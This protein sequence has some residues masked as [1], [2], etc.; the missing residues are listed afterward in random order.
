M[1]QTTRHRDGP[2]PRLPAIA[3]AFLLGVCLLHLQPDIGLP[4]WA[5][6][7][8]LGALPLL[9]WLFYLK[10]SQRFQLAFLIGY[11]WALLAAHS[12]LQQRLEPQWQGEDLLVSGQVSGLVDQGARSLRFNFR[13]EEVRYQGEA[14]DGFK[15]RYLRLSWYH[16][17]QS[18]LPGQRW[19]LQLRLKP[20][21][22]MLN[23]GGFDYEKWLFQQ[24]IH[25]TGYVRNSE[26]N[27]QISGA[28]FSING[29]RQQLIEQISAASDSPHRGLLHALSVGYKSNMRPQHWQVMINTGTSHLMAISGLHIGLVAGMVFFLARLLVPVSLLRFI[30][31]Q[32]FAALL[33]LLAAGFYAALAGFAVP[34]Q[35]AFV[36]LLVVLLALLLKRPA[37]SLNTLSLALL[38]VL[39]LDPLAPLSAGFW[40]S[41]IA[42]LLIAIIIGGRVAAQRGWLQGVRLQWL[43][44]LS[45][46][47]ISVLLFQQGS[48][49]S[50]LANML[51]IPLVGLLIVPMLLT[52]SLFSLFSASLSA[53]LFNAAGQILELTW[54]LLEWLAQSPLASWQ[55]ASL[56]LPHSLLA[57]L[58]GLLLILP[59]GFPLKATGLILLLP[60]IFYQAPRPQSGDFWLHLLDVGQG[61]S[62]L[63]QTRDHTLLYDAGASRGERFDLGRL[64]IEPLLRHKG[65][66][67][68][69]S[70]IISHADNDH[71][72]GADYLLQQF[73]V[74]KVLFGGHRSDFAYEL[75]A[76]AYNCR[77]GQRWRWNQV[78][79]ELLHPARDYHKTNQQSCVLRI[80]SADHSVLLTGDIDQPVESQ[81]IGDFSGQLRS[82]VLL[83]PHHGSK[84]SSSLS[85]LQQVEP[86]LALVSAGYLNRFRHPAGEVLQRY[87]QLGIPVLNTAED[88]AISLYF[89]RARLTDSEGRSDGNH[90]D[91][92]G[93]L[94]AGSHRQR[95]DA[96]HYWNH[97]L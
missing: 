83:V 12:Y 22:G 1:T 9:F 73:A 7:S 29:L 77:A 4:L 85:W 92:V 6:A 51:M 41:F 76:L 55:Q 46:L 50:P 13:I 31:K 93:G 48:L 60:M 21:H 61:L 40:L 69:D 75:P 35:R 20:P 63:V 90:I 33:S 82:D 84:S 3:L 67:S 64:V 2:G 36:M 65:I 8:L 47:P 26:A 72:G 25:A 52:A 91:G 53:W 86:Q 70:L 66:E 97:R 81:L 34:T 32:Q 45:M 37:F 16:T 58:G 28:G 11:L 95:K 88:G 68:L 62:V 5:D 19:Q 42:V 44:A 18:V 15:P 74:A 43:I 56:P 17:Q 57:L 78:S 80:A 24:G 89:T 59:R 39:L 10:P 71:A 87:R 30:S 38:A 96:A 23:P 54:P 49:I 94:S 14:L 27:R 79:F